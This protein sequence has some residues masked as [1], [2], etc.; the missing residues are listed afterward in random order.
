[1]GAKNESAENSFDSVFCFGGVLCC[2]GDL[3][4][5]IGFLNE[6]AV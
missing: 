3:V 1:M 5:A 6:R 2:L 4:T